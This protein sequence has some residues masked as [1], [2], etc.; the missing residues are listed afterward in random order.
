MLEKIK[1]FWFHSFLEERPSISLSLFRPFVA[2]TVGAH[3]IPTLLHLSDNYLTGS[4]R[5]KNPLFFTV[6][7]LRLVDQSP[8]W[9]VVAFMVLFYASVSFFM[10]GLFSQGSCLAMMLSLYFFYALNCLHIGTLSF[11]ILLVTLFLVA[12][13]SYP[14]DTFSIDSLRHPDPLAYKKKRPFFVQRL[15]QLQIASTYFFTALCKFTAQGNWFSDNPIYYLLNSPAEGVVKH[16]SLREFFAGQPSACYGIGIMMIAFEISMPFLLFMKRTRIFVIILGFLFHIMLV[17]TLHVPTI[18]FFLFPPQLLLFIE[19]EKIVD[20]VDRQ[21]GKN[22]N[23]NQDI[24]IFD[25]HCQF[26]IG[27]IEKLQTLDIFGKTKL[28]DYQI[29]ED[30]SSIDGRLTKEKCHSQ[31]HVLT[32]ERELFGG[33]YAFQ[34]LSMRLPL[35]W[36]LV[37]LFYFPGMQWVGSVI[38][39]FISK[40]RTLFHRKGACKNNQCFR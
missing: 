34:Y 25:G 9:L 13:T 33:F 19:P 16:F 7:V 2:F 10:V 17:V 29:F 30:I 27:S 21:R 20:F 24:V 4:F 38:Y 6:G 12:I 23:R 15:L 14:G 39:S 37:P 32:A 35:L 36:I 3:M 1:T 40:N 5:E 28:L 26:C 22:S 31:M 8:D 11:D 18:F